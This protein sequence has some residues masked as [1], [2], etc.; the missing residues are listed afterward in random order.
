MNKNYESGYDYYRR[1]AFEYRG[2]I[3][4]C[5]GFSFVTFIRFEG[6]MEGLYISIAFILGMFIVMFINWLM[7]QV[8][9]SSEQKYVRSPKEEDR[10]IDDELLA[11]EIHDMK[12]EIEDLKT[13]VKRKRG[14]PKK[15]GI[16]I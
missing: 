10:A 6:L 11:N 2:L 14:R 3:G 1:K 8:F 4:Y 15:N 16:K 9:Q 12:K 13:P 5:L 7:R